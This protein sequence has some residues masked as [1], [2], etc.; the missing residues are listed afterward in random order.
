M[1]LEVFKLKAKGLQVIL[2]MAQVTEHIKHVHGSMSPQ[3]ARH[4]HNILR[5]TTAVQIGPQLQALLN[6]SLPPTEAPPPVVQ[7][8]PKLDAIAPSLP[9]QQ[10]NAAGAT[11]ARQKFA[12]RMSPYNT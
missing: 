7:Q 8:S 4:V 3:L 5:D 12:R 10:T 11:H 9:Q 2:S 6:I 1:Q